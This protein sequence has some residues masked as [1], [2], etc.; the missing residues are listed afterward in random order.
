MLIL[1]SLLQ[2]RDPY[3]RCVKQMK[4]ASYFRTRSFLNSHCGRD[5]NIYRD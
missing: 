2:W 3:T 4:H 5:Q 1:Q